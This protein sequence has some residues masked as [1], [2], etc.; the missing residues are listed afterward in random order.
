MVIRKAALTRYHQKIASSNDIISDRSGT[1]LASSG[2]NDIV[3][4]ILK[5]NFTVG[6]F[7]ELVLKHIIPSSRMQAKYI[8]KLVNNTNISWV[9]LL[10]S[11]NICPWNTI[12]RWSV[13]FRKL[14]SYFQYRAWTGEVEYIKWRAACGTYEGLQND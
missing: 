5:S 8:A 12:P 9:K 7:P 14:K 10:K 11:H 3:L 4:E 1:S 2:D 6:Y 13:P